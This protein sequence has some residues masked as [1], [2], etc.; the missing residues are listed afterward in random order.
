[1]RVAIAAADLEL[2]QQLA[3][4]DIAEDEAGDGAVK[5]AEVIEGQHGNDGGRHG[6]GILSAQSNHHKCLQPKA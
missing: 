1:M 5:R 3:R 2:E 6:V 4:Q